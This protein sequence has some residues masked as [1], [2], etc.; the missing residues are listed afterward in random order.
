MKY[1]SRYRD[2]EEVIVLSHDYD[3]LGEVVLRDDDSDVPATNTRSTSY[4]LT[5][6][7]LPK[8]PEDTYMVKVTDDYTV[9]SKSIFDD[10]L[11]WWVIA[12]ANPHIRHPLDLKTADIIYLP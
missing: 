9:L 1:D 5:T 12:D 10:P 6:L 4:R 2:A 11:K 7:P 3:A 8:P